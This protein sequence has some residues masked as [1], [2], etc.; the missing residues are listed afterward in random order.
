M[1]KKP[2]YFLLI[3]VSSS[4]FSQ[5]F[6]NGDFEINSTSA[7]QINIS[8]SSFN[9][10]M[11][12]CTA[13]GMANE[14]DIQKISCGYGTP[15]SGIWFI[16]LSTAV[17]GNP[18]ALSITLSSSLIAG[19]NYQFSYFEQACTQFSTSIDSIQI[20]LS[21]SPN[22]FGN[23]IYSSLPIAGIWTQR[24]VNFTAPNNGNYITIK[25]LGIAKGWNFIDNFSSCNDFH[26]NLGNDTTLCKGQ[27]I[28]LYGGS[29]T[30]YLWSNG[31][32]NSSISVSSSG[33]YWL[34]ASNGLCSIS[35]TVNI[36][37]LNCEIEIE[38]PN[39]FS[40]N[41]DGVNDSFV[42]IKY[43]DNLNANL[44]IYNRWGVKVFFTNNLISGWDG[45]YNGNI[46]SDGTY[47]WVVQYL[48]LTNESRELHGSVTLI[49]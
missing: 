16:S 49:K 44:S 3:F 27:T 6:L 46:C 23:I 40:P 39:V 21:A 8:N 48:S 34:Q 10:F 47:F 17:I 4:C 24:I 20:G 41:G 43:N 22:S 2:I 26:L 14:L 29:A 31:L 45:S 1:L 12:N 38:Y 9:S 5:N 33:S 18:D 15:F 19:N 28:N 30:S 7:C 35:D 11:S 13:F 42:P 36:F 37:F 25:N 32:T